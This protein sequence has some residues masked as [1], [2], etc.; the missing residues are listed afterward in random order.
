M[1]D[2]LSTQKELPAPLLWLADAPMF[3]DSNFL[4][5]FYDAVVKPE[6]KVG[7]TTLTIT[8]ETIKRLKGATHLKG[9]ILAKPNDLFK[10][11]ASFFPFLNVE[12][13]VGANIQGEGGIDKTTKDAQM[14]ELFPIE[15]PQR[16]LVQLALHY[17]INHPERLFLVSD[18]AD[19]AWRD[20]ATIQRV[21]RQLVFL[22][23]PGQQE[24]HSSGRPEAKLIPTAAEFSDGKVVPLYIN[25][26]KK[27]GERPPHYAELGDRLESG[28]LYDNV[29]AIQQARKQYWQW[30]DD[31]FS[32]QQAVEI[33]EE[34]TFEHGR[35]RWIDYRVPIAMD[36]ST[37]HLHICPSDNY[38]TGVFAYNFIKRG[39]KHGLR[40][41][42]T[43]K[44]E[45]DMN[46]LAIY[47]K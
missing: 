41:V 44:S 46:T 45:P 27:N 18:P 11:I 37:L 16:Q 17:V 34:A 1:D 26:R 38:D 8:D 29:A 4:E 21:P 32:A 15:T 13:K 24:A 25:L 28:E 39:L 23:L 31:N 43:L 40:L 20:P 19:E 33:V 42:G 47:E 36:G 2:E 7:K 14:V 3:I 9:E 35:I 5:R 30:F 12:A 6:S 10:A 22:D